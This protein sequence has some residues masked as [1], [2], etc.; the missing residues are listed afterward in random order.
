MAPKRDETKP[1]LDLYFMSIQGIKRERR[2]SGEIAIVN[3][4]HRITACYAVSIEK[5]GRVGFRR[6]RKE[7]PPKDGWSHSVATAQFDLSGKFIDESSVR[8]VK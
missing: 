5:A 6:A 7:W 4:E 8:L 1:V 2:E 3:S